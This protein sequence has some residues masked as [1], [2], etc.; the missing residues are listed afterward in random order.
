MSLAF[1]CYLGRFYVRFCPI[2]SDCC[3]IMSDLIGFLNKILRNTFKLQLLCPILSDFSVI[4]TKMSI[5]LYY[6]IK[7][8]LNYTGRE[9]RTVENGIKLRICLYFF[10]SR[11][12]LPHFA[13][14][15]SLHG[16]VWTLT[17][18]NLLL[19]LFLFPGKIFLVCSLVVGS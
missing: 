19:I 9:F 7:M 18:E 6:E 10:I 15:F 4:C 11:K 16:K 8:K 14:L 13:P 17:T 1:L 5:L 12:N 3:P 2:S